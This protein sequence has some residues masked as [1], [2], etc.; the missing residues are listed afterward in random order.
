MSFK[1]RCCQ[2]YWR[3]PEAYVDHVEYVIRNGLPGERDDH[4]D[5]RHTS[6][7]TPGVTPG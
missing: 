3:T 6:H 7:V 2:W 4:V 1:C 5:T